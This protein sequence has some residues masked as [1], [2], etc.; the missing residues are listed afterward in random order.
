MR[1]WAGQP[2]AHHSPGK[3][4]WEVLMKPVVYDFLPYGRSN[5]IPWR[6]LAL[7]LGFKSKRELQKQIEA[8]RKCGYV[9]LTDFSGKGYFRSE[10]PDDLKRFIRTMEAKA[11][12][13]RIA[14]ISAERELNKATGQTA[15]D[16]W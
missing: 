5:A 8:E 6:D 9:I 2:A 14:I 3:Q 4:F 16:G 13:T 11:R 12:N 10:E 15:F 7:R 1:K